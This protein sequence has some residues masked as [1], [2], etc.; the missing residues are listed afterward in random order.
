MASSL[1]SYT[2]PQGSGDI[3]K[4]SLFQLN[5]FKCTNYIILLTNSCW[6]SLVALWTMGLVESFFNVYDILVEH[7]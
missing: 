6:V 2:H 3:Q 4:N 1:V 7:L 5:P